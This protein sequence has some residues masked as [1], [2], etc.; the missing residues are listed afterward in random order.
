MSGDGLGLTN[1]LA[2]E[3]DASGALLGPVAESSWLL[4]DPSGFGKLLVY[5]NKRYNPGEIAVTENGVSA[6]GEDSKTPE[7]AVKDT[8]RVDF[9]K[10]YFAAAEKAVREDNVP[11]KTYFVWSF[12]DNLEWAMG[13]KERFGITYVDYKS[14]DLTRIPKDSFKW[15]SR[16]YGNDV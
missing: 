4:V 9:F 10:G 2:H 11:L 1:Y 12:M 7:E 13:Y 3:K 5:L 16:L 15:L 8:F 14:K 6:P